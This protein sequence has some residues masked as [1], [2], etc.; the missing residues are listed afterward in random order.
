[1]VVE[2]QR[3]SQLE[4]SCVTVAV[5]AVVGVD[6]DVGDGAGLFRALVGAAVVVSGDDAV[7]CSG[8][9]NAVRRSYNPAA[10]KIEQVYSYVEIMKNYSMKNCGYIWYTLLIR[11]RP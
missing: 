8:T 7:V 5:G 2:V 6:L 1:M 9:G 4:Q 11:I 10:T 3:G